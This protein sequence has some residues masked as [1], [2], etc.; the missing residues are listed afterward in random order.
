[1]RLFLLP[2]FP[3]L[4]GI[5]I[6]RMYLQGGFIAIQPIIRFLR[7]LLMSVRNLMAIVEI[8]QSGSNVWSTYDKLQIYV[9]KGNRERQ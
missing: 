9:M 7:G 5:T 1:M 8:F 3:A 4:K 2:E 6:F